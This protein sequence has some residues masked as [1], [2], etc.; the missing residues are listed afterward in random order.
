MGNTLYLGLGLRLG[1]ASGVVP[2]NWTKIIVSGVVVSGL[3]SSVREQTVISG[4]VK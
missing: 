2:R 3:I 1:H 4:N